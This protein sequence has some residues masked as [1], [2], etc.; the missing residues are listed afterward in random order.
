MGSTYL[1]LTN[2]LLR[3]LNE[4]E[5]SQSDF[6][7]VRNIQSTA[8][9]AIF[10]TVNHINNH[11]PFWPFNATSTTQ[12][13]TIGQE[14]YAWPADF[15]VADW[16]SFQLVKDDTLGVKSQN[17]KILP[18]ELW[19]RYV[20]DLD[21]DAG[22]TGRGIPNNVFPYHGENFG[23]TPSPE[24]AYSVTYRY[25]KDPTPIDLYDDEVTIPSRFDYVIIAGALMHMYNFKDN[26]E[27]YDRIKSDFKTY[28]S[29]MTFQLIPNDD[30]V[31]AV[32]TNRGGGRYNGFIWTGY[33]P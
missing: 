33:N 25:Y 16:T 24:A 2:K 19:Q 15:V 13:L 20:K 28:L 17:L 7:S 11:K 10:D 8:K 3:R 23:V 4:V 22:A 29:D 27:A 1:D 30:S 14:I 21:D 6:P 18:R 26:I 9:D 12:I 5:I 32:Q 31:Y